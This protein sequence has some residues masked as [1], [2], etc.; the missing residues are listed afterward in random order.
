MLFFRSFFSLLHNYLSINNLCRPGPP[1]S[2]IVKGLQI[3]F[4]FEQ[5][6]IHYIKNNNPRREQYNVPIH[7]S[8]P[9]SLKLRYKL[10]RLHC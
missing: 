7:F 8:L 9:P 1:N 5:I 2:L 4:F 3:F 10:C 6:L